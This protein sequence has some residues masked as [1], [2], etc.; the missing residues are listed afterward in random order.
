MRA[1]ESSSLRAR[2]RPDVDAALGRVAVDL[3]ELLVAEVEA[4]E[5]GD[6]RFE[7]RD[8]ADADERGSDARI[9]QD[10]GHRHL[11]EGLAAARCDLVQGPDLD[12]RLV[13][14]QAGRQRAVA[15]GPRAFRNAYQVLVGQHSLLARPEHD[16]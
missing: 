6:I 10:P 4:L 1:P 9:A 15:A 11:R 3:R 2:G 14:D 12:D 7:L 5:R 8:A 13:G 16:A